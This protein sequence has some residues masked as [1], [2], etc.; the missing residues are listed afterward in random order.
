MTTPLI[1]PP[2]TDEERAEQALLAE[3]FTP[4][5]GLNLE[6]I[7]LLIG[8]AEKD[9]DTL[10]RY[11]ALGNW[12][13]WNQGHWASVRFDA[14]NSLDT[15]TDEVDDSEALTEM[16]QAVANGVCGTS[17]CMAGQAVVQA[18][19]RLDL[20]GFTGLDEGSTIYTETGY[21]YPQQWTG[22]Y[23]DKGRRIMRDAG[24]RQSIAQVARNVLGLTGSQSDGF[25]SGGNTINDLKAYANEFAVRAGM[26]EPY[27]GVDSDL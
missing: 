4:K 5:D 8:W 21:C 23:D 24:H 3:V 12:G 13:D 9:R 10:V 25:F 11:R 22:R 1:R 14:A 26:D 27:P 17:F 6:A 15:Q 2:A 7:R 16:E 20:Q 19:H 18:G